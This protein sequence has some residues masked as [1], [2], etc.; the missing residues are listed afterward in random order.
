MSRALG[1]D[2]YKR[3]TCVTV[4]VARLRTLTAQWQRVPSIGQNLQPFTRIGDISMSEIF[5]SGTINPKQTNKQR[6]TRKITEYKL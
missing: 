6:Q 4:D 3:M 5:S 1:D 2:Y